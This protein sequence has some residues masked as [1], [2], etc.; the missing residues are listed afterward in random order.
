MD[1]KE[2]KAARLNRFE[3]VTVSE[4]MYNII[5]GLT[6]IWGLIIN[7]IEAAVLPQ[8]LFRVNFTALMI[9]Y[10]VGSIGCTMLVYKSANPVFSLLGFTGLA[11]FMGLLLT[12]FLTAYDA[13]SIRSAVL[14]TA[15]VTVAMMLASTLFPNFF[16]GM[17]RV[18]MFCL[19]VSLA[20]SVIGGLIFNMNLQAM[21]YAMVVVFSCYIG[22]D[23]AKAQ[24]YPKTIDNAIDSTAD[25]YVDIINIFIRILSIMGNGKKK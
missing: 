24:M 14:M 20:V 8:Y 19:L 25:I 1:N 18:L 9:V 11:F 22:Y 17:G 3:G 16:L 12:V 7:M 4:N 13:G 5:I 21:D 23:W 2:Y 6:L 10:L 15:I